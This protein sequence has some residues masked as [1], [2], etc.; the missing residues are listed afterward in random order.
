MNKYTIER[1]KKYDF[2]L[3][4]EVFHLDQIVYTDDMAG[5]VEG[6]LNRYK[7]AE[8]AFLLLKENGR[9]IGYFCF[10]PIKESLFE[11]MLNSDVLYD[12]NIGPEDIG[13]Y[14]KGEDH[15]IF[16]ISMVIHPSYK[17]KGLFSQLTQRF[18]QEILDYQNN[19]YNISDISGYA[20]SGAGEYILKSFG[21]VL[22]KEVDDSGTIGK[23]YIAK[24]ENFFGG[25]KSE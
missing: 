18:K 21:S 13:H 24:Q 1:S 4:E 20:V 17:G 10:F 5:S 15:H 23:L 22:Y 11:K 9:V 19:G 16:I 8:D 25:I 7:K 12:N 2:D 14:V 6:D 3:I